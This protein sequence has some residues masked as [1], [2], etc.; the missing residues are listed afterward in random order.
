MFRVSHHPRRIAIVLGLL[1]PAAVLAHEGVKNPAVM[2]RMDVMSQIGAETKVIGQMV[3][4]EIP[5]DVDKARAAVTAIAEQS[6]KVPGLFEA[7][8][9][10]PKSEALPAIWENFP[11]FTAKT[12]AME[13]AARA[14]SN[15]QTSE[16]LA[17]ALGAI[18]ETCKDCH[19]SYRE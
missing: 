3:K 15:L 14:A 1:V 2:A 4:G 18:G 9:D 7:R 16:E 19:R 11:D 10:D 12:E 6:T 13:E 5:F 8:E 17:A